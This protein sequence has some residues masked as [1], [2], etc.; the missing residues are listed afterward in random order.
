MESASNIEGEEDLYAFLVWNI[1]PGSA[2][3]SAECDR[4]ADPVRTVVDRLELEQFKAHIKGLAR[5]GDRMQGTRAQPRCP[6]LD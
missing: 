5:F 4:A 1:R 2:A 6:R 3:F